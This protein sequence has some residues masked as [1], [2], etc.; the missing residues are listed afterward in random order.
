MNTIGPSLS[1]WG[2]FPWLRF[3]HRDRLGRLLWL[4][5]L[6]GL[7]LGTVQGCANRV[8]S[9][10]SLKQIETY[11]ATVKVEGIVGD[12]VP[13]VDHYVYELKDASGTIWV[14]TATIP[15]DTSSEQR[16][17][18]KGTLQRYSM[19][20]LGNGYSELLLQELSHQTVE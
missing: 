11:P 9:I 10:E 1:V 20:D 12:R 18:V 6:F 19:S 16:V 7:S 5:T 17:Q 13:F 14:Q 15:P 4:G 2:R 3:G 8:R